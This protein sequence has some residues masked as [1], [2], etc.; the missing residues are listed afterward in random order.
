MKVKRVSWAYDT[1]LFCK[2]GW[3]RFYLS[4]ILQAGPLLL[5]ISK[6][7]SQITIFSLPQS[8]HTGSAAS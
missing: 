2:S 3:R 1:T 7:P 4:D 6:F 5:S 8:A